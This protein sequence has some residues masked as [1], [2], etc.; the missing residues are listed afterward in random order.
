MEGDEREGE[1]GGGYVS[2]F[3]ELRIVSAGW[4]DI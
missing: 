4:W 2:S 1:R 3:E